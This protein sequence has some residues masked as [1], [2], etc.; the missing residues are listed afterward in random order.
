MTL[1]K[2]S[3]KEITGAIHLHTTYSDGGITIRELIKA[4]KSVDLD[5]IIVT[6]HMTLGALDDG[7]EGFSDKL[8]VLVGYEHHDP[9]KRNHYLALGVNQ[10]FD[11]TMRPQSYVDEIKKA[12]GIG[13]LAHPAEKRNYFGNLPPY[14]WTDWEV[15]GFD[16][17]E[18][19]NQMS[20]W[21]EN[22]KSWMSF[23]KLFYPRRFLGAPPPE[24]LARWDSLNKSR[25]VSG[26]G[27]VDAH[28]RRLGIGYCYFRVFPIKVELKGIRTHLYIDQKNDLSNFASSKN[29]IL[30]ALRCGHGFISNFR[31]GDA[32]GSIFFLEHKNGLISF[33][34]IQ[35][36]CS[37]PARLIVQ[38]PE[39]G[40]IRFIADGNLIDQID[41]KSAE[42]KIEK[43]GV[44]RVEVYRKSKAWIYSNPIPIDAYPF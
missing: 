20:D 7:Y 12:G 2:D 28:S 35:T 33:P 37:L 5:F 23:F 40:S 29:T 9:D 32:S 21:V 4:A 30:N 42:F 44:Y 38:I 39:K 17:I 14:P 34:G 22:L 43:N 6:D 25:F 27:G 26:I 36:D 1:K 18:I 16:G 11:G 31:R 41:G 8:C 10:V 15:N 3:Y 24:L 13:F 19:W